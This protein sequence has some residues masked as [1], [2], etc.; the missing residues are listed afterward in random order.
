MVA[1]HV[2]DMSSKFTA[3]ER[4]GVTQAEAA[5]PPRFSIVKTLAAELVPTKVSGN[6]VRT[7]STRSLG[8]L[9]REMSVID[10]VKVWDF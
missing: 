6:A 1:S 4:T 9:E 7:G 8:A 3:S 10:E 2:S 5:S